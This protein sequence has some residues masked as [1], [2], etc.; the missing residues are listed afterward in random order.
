MFPLLL[1]VYYKS[2]NDFL[3]S[4]PCSRG[5]KEQR[6]KIRNIPP[7]LLVKWFPLLLLLFKQVSWYNKA[8]WAGVSKCKLAG[9]EGER[10]RDL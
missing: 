10:L 8:E 3:Q 9:S 1:L 5:G 7:P 4:G 6:G 2:E